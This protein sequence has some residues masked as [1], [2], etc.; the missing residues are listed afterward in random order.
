MP[1]EDETS[2]RGRNRA[3]M[4][5][6]GRKTNSIRITCEG[7]WGKKKAEGFRVHLVV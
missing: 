3:G 7:K 5:E 6:F 1:P 2:R 4:V